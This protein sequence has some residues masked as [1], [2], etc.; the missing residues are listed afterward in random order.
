MSTVKAPSFNNLSAPILNSQF[1]TI[2]WL[3]PLNYVLLH[4]RSLTLKILSQRYNTVPKKQRRI[5]ANDLKI[6]IQKIATSQKLKQPTSVF[7]NQNQQFLN[8]FI[9]KLNSTIL[10]HAFHK[11]KPCKEIRRQKELTSSQTYLKLSNIRNANLAIVKN[12]QLLRLLV[13]L[14]ASSSLFHPT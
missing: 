5:K 3:Q 1:L 11:G 9:G 6:K 14:W 13:L 10:G 2:P 8:Y 4:Y 12:S 7:T